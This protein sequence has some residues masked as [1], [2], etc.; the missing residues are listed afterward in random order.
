MNVKNKFL[1]LVPLSLLATASTVFGTVPEPSTIL[2]GQVLHRA[3][4]NEHQLTEGTLEWTLRDELG[5]EF[6]YTT[7]LEDIKSVFSYKVSIPHQALS[8]GLEVDPTVIPLGVGETDYEFV[9]ITVDGYPAAI[10]WSEV[11]YLELVQNSR[12]ATHRIDL[13]VSFDLLDTDGDGMPDWWEKFYGLDWQLNDAAGDPDGDGWTNLEEYY[14]GTDPFFDNRSPVLQGASLSAMAESTNGVWLRAVDANTTP[15]EL[16]F[17]LTALPTGG[18]LLRLSQGGAL[19][20][21]PLALGD[22]FSQADLND[23]LV[24]YEHNDVSTTTDMLG[25]SLSDGV[26]ASVDT[27]V[28]ISV[29]PDSPLG[30]DPELSEIPF[31]WRDENVV[32]AAYWGLRE[33]VL[34]GGIVETAL[35]Y[36]L[37][38]DY[39]WTLWDYRHETLPVTI[40]A[41]GDGMNFLLGGSGDDVLAGGAGTDILN[42][43]LGED[44][45]TGGADVDMFIIGEGAFASISDFSATEDVIDF[46]TVVSGLTGSLAD[47]VRLVVDGADSILEVHADGDFDTA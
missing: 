13:L 30:N 17:T 7:E 25:V 14:L 42:G 18:R 26:H 20:D 11:D 4:G 3:F 1:A 35:L 43:G 39:G 28:A 37:G 16:E 36:R 6:T 38:K 19:P 10:L 5:A 46:G 47:Y 23:G 31:W 2:Y 29:F 9:S 32:Y 24:V 34:N 27:E 41:T 44:Q 33:N 8:S 15:E 45:L 40:A 12:A 22:R 21:Y